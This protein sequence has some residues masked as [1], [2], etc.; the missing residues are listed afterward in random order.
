MVTMSKSSRRPTR[1]PAASSSDSS[2]W[3]VPKVVARS[4]VRPH[5]A[6]IV[7]HVAAGNEVMVGSSAEKAYSA[8]VPPAEFQRRRLPLA[9]KEIDIDELRRN[10]S[11]EREQVENTGRPI[12]ILR[13]R[14]PAV[15]FIPTPR[16]LEKKVARTI[17]TLRHAELGL[18]HDLKERVQALEERMLDAE[19]M[20]EFRRAMGIMRVVLNDWREKQGHPPYSLPT[21]K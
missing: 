5:L 7:R 9:A 12:S 16:A 18:L 14:E 20:K 15:V 8:F 10:W 11:R 1:R 21:A 13:K 19:E 4:Q 2:R 3:P 6:Q 17:E